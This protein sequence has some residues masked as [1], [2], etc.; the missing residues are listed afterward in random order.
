MR[1]K[2]ATLILLCMGIMIAGFA[3]LVYSIISGI[4]NE[5]MERSA[6]LSAVYGIISFAFGYALIKN[7]KLDFELELSKDSLRIYS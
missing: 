7:K 3:V 1:I 5:R 6:A 4:G 2:A